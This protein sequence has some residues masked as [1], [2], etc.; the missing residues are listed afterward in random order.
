MAE[1]KVAEP[2]SAATGMAVEAI[3]A[4]H[5]AALLRYA[6]RLLHDPVAAQDVV[7]EAFVRLVRE[8]DAGRLPPP[9]TWAG[10]LHRVTHNAA[11]D[12]LRREQRLRGLHR[13]QAEEPA[14]PTATAQP[15]ERMAYVLEL[16]R[17]LPPA[18]QEVLVLRLQE[19]RS[20]KEISV[21]TGRSEG[22][23]GCLL[24]QAVKTLA[25]RLQKA[26]AL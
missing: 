10:W 15:E 6:A 12:Y 17:R 14:A 7:Q 1:S 25:A 19:G 13:R 20:Y 4:E 18:E 8:H 2:A 24:H 11:V 26:G 22:N 5:Q 3:V 23:V 9:D 16:A 21:L